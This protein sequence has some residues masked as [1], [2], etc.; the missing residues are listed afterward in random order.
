MAK[1]VQLVMHGDEIYPTSLT[2]AIVMPPKT[3]K[4]NT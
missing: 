3:D 1:I 4:D 2:D